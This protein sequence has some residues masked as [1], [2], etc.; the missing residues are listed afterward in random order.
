MKRLILSLFLFVSTTIIAQTDYKTV[1][2]ADSIIKKG[3]KLYEEKKYQASLDEYRK[4]DKLDPKYP[5][6]QYEIAMSYFALEKKDS[7]K[8]HF[9][10]IYKTDMM[11]KLPTLY[12][13]YGSY[14]SD[15]KKYDES[16]KIFNEGLKIIPNS[17]NHLYNMAILYYRKEQMQKCIDVLEKIIAQNPNQASAHYLLG[18][19]AY[20]S[21][22]IVEGT[23]GM[24]SYLIISPTGKFAK[25]AI[26]KMNAKYGDNYLEKKNLVFSK[27]GDNF[28]ELET[29]LRNGL[30]LRNAYKVQSKIDDVVTRQVQA[31]FE[32]SQTHKMGDGFFETIY[33]PWIKSVADQK[34]T[35]HF[36]YYMLLVL[37][38]DL[39]K[40]L[41]AQKKKIFQF[42]EEYIAKD[43]WKYF[44]KRNMNFF[45]TQQD[46]VVY[47]DDNIP[48]L[49]GAVVNDKREGKFKLLN[50]YENLDGELNFENNELN[51]VQK[52]YDEEGKLSEEKSYAKGKLDG[53]RTVYYPSGNIS[54]VE[55]YKDGELEGKSTSY[56]VNGGINCDG[57]FIKGELD[58]SLICYYPD[59]SKK[60]DSKYINGK[61]D[62]QYTTYN[63]VGDIS[64]TESYKNGE[65]NGKYTK[66]Y[67][68][69]TIAEEA[70]YLNDKVVGSFKKY[71]PN[72]KLK[73]EYVYKNNIIASSTEYY[74]T[75][76]KSGESTYNEKGDLMMTTYFNPMGEKSYEELFNT[77][78]IKFIKQYSR[79]N[80]KPTE[81]NLAR[82]AFEI[83]TLDGKVTATGS[84]ERGKR[85]GEWKNFF[86]SGQ[87][88][89]ISNFSKGQQQGLNTLYNKTGKLSS[90]R[91]YENDTLQGRND[92]FTDRGL[93]KTFYY[94]DGDLNGPYKSYYPDGKLMV[95]G[96]YANDDLFG[97]RL[98]YSQN[99]RLISVESCYKGLVTSDDLYNAKGEK[100][101][102]VE[103]V[104]KTGTFSYSLNNGLT[105][106]TY[107]L[108][109]G[110]VNGAYTKK[111]K[112]NKPLIDSE[113]RNGALHKIYREYGPNDTILLEQTYYNGDV[114]G[115]SN[116]Y[117]LT[118]HLKINSEYLFGDEYGKTTRYY[119]NKVKMYEYSQV[120]D[121]M[122]GEYIYYNQKGEP[123]VSVMYQDDVPLYY[124]KRSKTGQLT[125]KVELVNE[126]GV[127]TSNYAN[128]KVAIQFTLD[129]GLK[130][131]NFVINNELGKPEYT[132]FYTKDLL[133]KERIE[134]YP[135][136]TIYLKERFVDNDYEGV[137]E[138]FTADGKPWI[139]AEYKN[140][141]LHGKT[142]I[143]TNGVLTTTKKYDSDILVEITK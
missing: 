18:L 40:N 74:A 26:L 117:D 142:Q 37:E 59:G 94:R 108:K 11:K 27:T 49:I 140:D 30:P 79:N 41:T 57:N 89:M 119:N 122:E 13:L 17:S 8:N 120:D 126:T 23:M 58:G 50:K 95:E 54:L 45:G 132:C 32:Y 51:G 111:D 68:T 124:T 83:K 25:N 110:Y 81:I 38:N 91:N 19:M 12:T 47:L 139:K 2:N 99:G 109:N 129:K 39:G 9:E 104:N 48:N 65:L 86:N 136:G 93:R 71:Y 116:N 29:I 130:E 97:K 1:Y 70:E 82:K 28:E 36:S 53:K 46:V 85:N 131:G 92:I 127:I 100:E 4:V 61:M 98:T 60:S 42:S 76:M 3:V 88:Q 24:L 52:Y 43:F 75:G 56:N 128:G 20:D 87:L 84:F 67:D 141:E 33:M 102:T 101:A 77:K 90:I 62:G 63:K 16:E 34:F 35:E 114:N 107:N 138:Y 134:Y 118:G 66:Y 105:T 15:E 106:Q 72:K 44:A 14:L 5:T 22:K 31:L 78:E 10:R 125:E 135:N 103:Y 133:N 55:N 143:Y 121:T 115:Y 123:L 6:A 96:F 80:P 112:N 21:G 137:Q 7:L 69:K 113:Y 64:T 73:E